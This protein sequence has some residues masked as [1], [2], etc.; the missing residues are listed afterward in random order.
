[1]RFLAWIGIGVVIL[2]VSFLYGKN[3][4]ALRDYL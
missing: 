1:V 3:R 2:V 4:D